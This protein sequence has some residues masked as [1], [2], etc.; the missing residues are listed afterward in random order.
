MSGGAVVNCASVSGLVGVP[1]LVLDT[2]SKHAIIGLTRAAAV[3]RRAQAVHPISALPS[4][5]ALFE[6][7]VEAEVLPTCRERGI[8]FVPDRPLGRGFLT[9]LVTRGTTRS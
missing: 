1:G 7:H 9:G 6:R 2:A 8:G 5:D 4:E 3:L